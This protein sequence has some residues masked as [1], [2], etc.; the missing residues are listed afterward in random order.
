M[1]QLLNPQY[2][3]ERRLHGS[4]NQFGYGGKENLC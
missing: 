3:R 4:Q 1:L 2:P